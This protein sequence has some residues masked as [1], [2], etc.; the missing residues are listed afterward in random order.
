MPASPPPITVTRLMRARAS[1]TTGVWPFRC[2]RPRL[3]AATHAFS[4]TGSEIRCSSTSR[5]RE[6]DPVE[7][8]AVDPGHREH[9]RRAAAVEQLD[10]LQ[11]VVEPLVGARG[12][13]PD[14]LGGLVGRRGEQVLAPEPAEILGGQVDPAAVVVLAD[15]SQDVGQLHRDPEVVGQ[16]RCAVA[17]RGRSLR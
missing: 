4:H 13:E 9:A 1:F 7:D 17:S 11:S 12:L 15:V 14:Q 8:P 10:Q 3:R 16:L 2:P 5:A 6:R